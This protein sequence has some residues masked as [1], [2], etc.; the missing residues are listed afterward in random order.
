MADSGFDQQQ[1]IKE[2]NKQRYDIVV[3][4]VRKGKKQIIKDF[5]AK[6]GLS[7]TELI[8]RAVESTWGIDMSKGE[9]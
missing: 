7:M 6:Q 1:Y 2:Y 8:A 3:V 5:A 4:A 9:L